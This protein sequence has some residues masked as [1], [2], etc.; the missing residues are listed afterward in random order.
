M[1]N[2]ISVVFQKK[3]VLGSAVSKVL[4]T[5]SDIELYIVSNVGDIA[6]SYK[7]KSVTI[8]LVGFSSDDLNKLYWQGIRSSLLNPVIILGYS[9]AQSF[10]K[11]NPVFKTRYHYYIEAPWK[12]SEIFNAFK[13]VVPLHD[14]ATRQILYN[15]YGGGYVLDRIRFLTNHELKN[16]DIKKNLEDLDEA[17]NL[18]QKL[19]DIGLEYLLKETIQIRKSGDLEAFKMSKIELLNLLNSD[20]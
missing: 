16:P 17:L 3:S 8:M 11:L 15:N 9:K 6:K 4:H 10:L 2:Q 19:H 5:I 18:S 14:D 1:A 7:D 13:E 20:K 12:L